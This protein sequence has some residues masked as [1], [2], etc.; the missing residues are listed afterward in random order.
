[1]QCLIYLKEHGAKGYILDDRSMVTVI[2]DET[3][4]L[5]SGLEGY[6]S[7]F[8]VGGSAEGVTLKNLEY[9]IED[10]EI[11]PDFPVGVSNAFIG[12]SAE[13]T[14]KK[15]MLLVIINWGRS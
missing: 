6:L 1:M 5:S 15:G 3:V 4:T 10:E 8:A 11:R 2:K 14:V 13:I 9:E 12:K 7:V